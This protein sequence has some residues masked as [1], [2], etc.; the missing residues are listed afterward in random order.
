[1]RASRH[2][3]IAAALL[4]ASACTQVR[5]ATPSDPDAMANTSVDAL[6]PSDTYLVDAPARKPGSP[7]RPPLADAGAGCWGKPA[8]PCPPQHV[9]CTGDPKRGVVCHCDDYRDYVINRWTLPTDDASRIGNAADLDGDGLL[10]NGLGALLQ[11]LKGI[12]AAAS[13]QADLDHTIDS[14]AA[15]ALL[16][17]ATK[18][19]SFAETSR[20]SYARAVDRSCCDDPSDAS[21]C[22]TQ[23]AARCFSGVATFSAQNGAWVEA[24]ATVTAGRIAASLPGSVHISLPL[25]VGGRA[26]EVAVEQARIEGQLAG[27]AITN[28][29]LVGVIRRAELNKTLIPAMA[30]H[31]D[32]LIH[33]TS[34][35]QLDRTALAN[36][37]D[38]NKDGTISFS[39]VAS[40][41]LIASILQDVDI[42]KDG[43]FELSVGLGFSAVRAVV[44]N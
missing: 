7:E 26:V 38:G 24:P 10:D 42:D 17:V 14:G 29:R 4:V 2:L 11:S 41:A 22:A 33:D 8:C 34:V 18:T 32:A 39:E 27:D 43:T 35:S 36:L 3:T 21:S 40:N 6:Y 5:Y 12:G 44:N 37:L 15:L 9:T 23:A 20:L 16:R 31:F 1:M 30:A 13:F 25:Y 19:T 28:G